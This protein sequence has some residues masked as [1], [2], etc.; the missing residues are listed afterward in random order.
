MIDFYATNTPDGQKIAIMLEECGLDYKVHLTDIEAL[1]QL[2]DPPTGMPRSAE[3]PA[4]VDRTNRSE[5]LSLFESGEVLTH[6]AEM[7]GHFLPADP[8]EWSKVLKW[9]SLSSG[10]DGGASNQTLDLF[11]VLEAQLIEREWLAGET[12]SIADIAAYPSA[13]A[14]LEHATAQDAANW[15]N[16]QHWIR[17]VSLRPAVGRAN[18]LL[19]R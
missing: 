16:M 4:I 6:L 7:S 5:P 13:R 1:E 2:S 3:P 12:F 18:Q 14:Q 15:P 11:T 17:R 9:T 19:A 10:A 8:V